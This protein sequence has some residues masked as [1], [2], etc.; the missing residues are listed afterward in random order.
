MNLRQVAVL[1]SIL[2]LGF[3]AVAGERKISF[4]DLPNLVNSKN[5]NVLAA[6]SALNAQKERTGRLTRSFLPNISAQVGAEEFQT[7]SDPREQQGFWRVEG[8]LNLYRGGRDLLEEK[9]RESSI[10]QASSEFSREFN[11]ELKE[12]QQAYWKLVAIQNDINDRK[13]GLSKNE[14]NLK[15]SRRRSGAGIATGADSVQFELQ[16][17]ILNQDLKKLELLQDSLKNKLSVAVGLD[18]HESLSVVDTF[19]HPEEGELKAPALEIKEQS[20]V[21]ALKE[22]EVAENLRRDQSSRWWLPRVDLYSNYGLP[23]LSDE[24]TRALRKDRE[25]AAGVRVGF[26]LGQSFEDRSEAR[27]RTFESESLKRRAA[28]RSREVVASDHDFRHDLK[29]LHELIH[30]A[31]KDIEKAERFLKLTKGEY[32]RGVKN[33]P[34]LLEA[35][36]MLYEF[37]QRRN[38]L[39]RDYF[40]T[41][42]ELLSLV[43]KAGEI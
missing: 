8:T 26:D 43:A 25:W 12:A 2:L 17:T 10:R 28:H 34:D 9:I 11:Q 42:S 32:A 18:E 31:D 29:L 3:S 14:L 36:K 6:S 4:E 23:S 30:D 7:G 21:T 27:S 5:E 22:K 19:P 15:S 24:Y 1:S 35:F 13:E 40:E 16:K 37:R 20:D 39:Y 41:K 33:G 38:D